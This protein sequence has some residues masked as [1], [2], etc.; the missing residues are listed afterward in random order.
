MLYDSSNLSLADLKPFCLLRNAQ[1][2]YWGLT[3]YTE[4]LDSKLWS[5][6]VIA[7][8][9]DS[10]WNVFSS[11]IFRL[12]L[13]EEAI[14][15]SRVRTVNLVSFC[16][17]ITRCLMIFKSRLLKRTFLSKVEAC[18]V[19]ADQYMAFSTA[20]V[21]CNRFKFM[22]RQEIVSKLSR[23]TIAVT[24][25]TR[26]RGLLPD[27]WNLSR[28]PLFGQVVDSDL[29]LSVLC[30]RLSWKHADFSNDSFFSRERWMIEGLSQA[31]NTALAAPA[32]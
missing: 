14:D 21:A 7:L 13:I 1:E 31:K 9:I 3:R 18:P 11:H 2:Q 6:H 17:S 4:I 5:T 19:N 30:T 8:D 20:N 10:G 22:L 32:T 16:Q 15:L 25:P 24:G 27:C 23:T 28:G 29:L 12:M 26:G